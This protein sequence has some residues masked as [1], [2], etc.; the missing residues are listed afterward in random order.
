MPTPG[1]ARHPLT[2]DPHGTDNSTSRRQPAAHGRPPATR[3]AQPA[4]RPAAGDVLA[5]QAHLTDRDRTIIDWVDR[6]GVLTTTQLTAAWFTSPTTAA[7]R[8]AKLRALGLLDRFHRPAPGAWFTPWH[9]VIGP[10]GAQ[11]T[12]AT[13]GTSAPT[14]QTL[15]ARHAALANSTKLTHLLGVNQFFIDLHVHTRHHPDT[16][17]VR[18]WSEAETAERFHGLIHPDGH[19]LWRHG[20]TLIGVFVEHDT[21]SEP[22]HRVVGKLA[23]YDQLAANGGPRYPIL[24]WLPNHARETHLR[25]ELTQHRAGREQAVATAVAT[26]G[27]PGP[28]G[29]VWALTDRPGRWAL[30]QLPS[31]HGDPHSPYT[32]AL[33]EPDPRH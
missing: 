13:A 26:P 10:L 12:A 30:H 8:L 5:V 28:A 32:P 21:G 14:P 19:A 25:H 3:P 29:G 7:H 24:F 20:D 9:W 2:G 17:L 11:I 4:R 18:W 1:P 6:H 22:L 33:T 23:A 15:R 31:T 27:G 16:T